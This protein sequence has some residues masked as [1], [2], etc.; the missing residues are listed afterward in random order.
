MWSHRLGTEHSVPQFTNPS[1]MEVGPGPSDPDF[2]FHQSIITIY[3][4]CKTMGFI[5]TFLSTLCLY[6]AK[7]TCGRRNPELRHFYTDGSFQ[8][9]GWSYHIWAAMVPVE[10]H[11]GL[12]FSDDSHHPDVLMLT[13]ALDNR[14]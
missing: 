12:E 10:T 13:V 14:D 9:Y 2:L 3:L 4:L 11:M 7:Q 6:S 1:V 5:M 8:I